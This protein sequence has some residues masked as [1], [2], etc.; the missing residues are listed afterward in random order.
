MNQ[1]DQEKTLTCA[2]FKIAQSIRD[3]NQLHHS[4][5]YVV[6]FVAEMRAVLEEAS[7]DLSLLHRHIK[8]S[9]KHHIY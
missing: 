9:R 6:K 2:E 3:C 5:P 4:D 1:L 7:F 8:S